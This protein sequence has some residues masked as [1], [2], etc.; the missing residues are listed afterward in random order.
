MFGRWIFLGNVFCIG[1]CTMGFFASIGQGHHGYSLVWFILT[2]FNT[3]SAIKLYS[4]VF[5]GKE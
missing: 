1:W 5:K 3:I 4:E 2:I